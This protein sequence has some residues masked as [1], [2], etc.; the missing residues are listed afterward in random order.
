MEHGATLA[1]DNPAIASFGDIA[2]FGKQVADTQIAEGFVAPLTDLGLIEATGEE[3]AG[4]LHNQLTNDVEHLGPGT[5]RLAGYCSPKGRLM[6]T[7]L[8]WK[9][10]ESIFLQLPHHLQPAIQRRLQMFILRSKV[11]LADASDRFVALGLGG[12]KAG[13]ALRGHFPNLPG[14]PFLAASSEAGTLI[15]LADAG[16]QPRYQWIAPVETA[17]AAWPAL[18]AALTPAGTSTWRLTEIRAGMPVITQ[19][20]QE[21]FVPQMINF[22]LVGGVNFKKGCYPGQ[23]I[24][25]RSQYLGKLKRRMQLAT[26]AS[27][28]EDVP[29][30]GELF[31]SEDPGQPCGM[32]VNAERNA[33]GE[34]ECLVEIKLAALDAGT[35]HLGAPDGP[36]L[37]FGELPYPLTDPA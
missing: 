24:V 17:Q 14:A 3:A 11:K 25:A 21:Q 5:A 32:V 18:C 33:S 34:T 31:S 8:T 10:G 15:R 37:R 6:A 28:S 4:F 22:E 30:G 29:V 19:G 13:A 36:A 12:A 27:E 26:I 1:T 7:F 23:E 16:G 9:Q 20:T 2:S 35:I